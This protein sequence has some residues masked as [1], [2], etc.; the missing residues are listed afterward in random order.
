MKST[1]SFY[2]EARQ[3]GGG[4]P[5]VPPLSA[6]ILYG[7]GR[8]ISGIPVTAIRR[9]AALRKDGVAWT[10]IARDLMISKGKLKRAFLALPEELR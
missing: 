7:Q 6:Y 1:A 5:R 9:T 4:A 8:T 2:G 3:V 10:Q